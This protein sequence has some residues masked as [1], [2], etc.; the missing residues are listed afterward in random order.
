MSLLLKVMGQ[1]LR[2][3]HTDCIACHG[4]SNPGTVTSFRKQCGECRCAAGCPPD[5]YAHA[6][7]IIP[8][9][10][11]TESAGINRHIVGDERALRKRRS[12]SIPASSLACDLARDG[13]EA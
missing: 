6:G 12:E 9:L 1:R 2:R 8:V 13:S 3:Q 7:A 4:D 10:F 5:I 11:G